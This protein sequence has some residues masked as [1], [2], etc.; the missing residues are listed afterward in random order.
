MTVS[1]W[2]TPLLSR[3]SRR[4]CPWSSWPSVLFFWGDAHRRRGAGRWAY[5]RITKVII[6]FF[7][8]NTLLA[9]T[10]LCAP[11]PSARSRRVAV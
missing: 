6:F 11:V 9:L 1:P 2:A 4:Y 7:Y 10:V 8:K 5:K 3:L